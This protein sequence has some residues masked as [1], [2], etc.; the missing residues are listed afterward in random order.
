MT[1]PPPE[2][3]CRGTDLP[4][5]HQKKKRETALPR[6]IKI[7]S[8]GQPDIWSYCQPAHTRR[9]P[10]T[11]DCC[12]KHT[13]ICSQMKEPHAP[14]YKVVLSEWLPRGRGANPAICGASGME[15]GWY[16]NQQR[17]RI[18]PARVIPT[19]ASTPQ[20]TAGFAALDAS[21]GRYAADRRSSGLMGSRVNP[22]VGATVQR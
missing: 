13:H 6:A 19:Y 8:C 21:R 1:P 16:S 18:R 11:L 3:S 15:C 12:H 7:Q 22:L 10:I 9:L 20:V 4:N 5:H 14:Q 17:L 2:W